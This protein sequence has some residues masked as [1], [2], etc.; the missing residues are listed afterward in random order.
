MAVRAPHV[1]HALQRRQP[2]VRG[3]DLDARL[4]GHR[5]RRDVRIVEH[6]HARRRL[7]APSGDGRDLDRPAP[8]GERSR[9]VERNLE[10]PAVAASA[11]REVDRSDRGPTRRH[12]PLDLAGLRPRDVRRQ[13]DLESPFPLLRRGPDDPVRIDRD[14]Q[15]GNGTDGAAHLALR[16]VAEA[17]R[18]ISLQEKRDSCHADPRD[19][20]QRRR[21]E[22]FAPERIGNVA[23]VIECPGHRTPQEVGERRHRSRGRGLPGPLR[24]RTGGDV[25]GLRRGRGDLPAV[26]GDEL[27]RIHRHRFTPGVP[28]RDLHLQRI[29]GRRGLAVG[30][31]VH[32]ELRRGGERG[33]SQRD[34]FVQELQ[35]A[36]GVASAG[37][38]FRPSGS[39]LREDRADRRD[40]RGKSGRHELRPRALHEGRGLAQPLLDAPA[41]GRIA[42]SGGDGGQPCIHPCEEL[43]RLRPFAPFDPGDLRLVRAG[44]LKRSHVLGPVQAPARRRDLVVGA[45]GQRVHVAGRDRERGG[46]VLVVR[47]EKGGRP[48][49]RA[50]RGQRVVDG[51]ADDPG[52]LVLAVTVVGR[53]GK[54]R[55]HDLRTES[56]R[57]AHRVFEHLVFRPEAP[58]LVQRAR[59]AEVVRP[60]EELPRAVDAPRSEELLRPHEA[61]RDAEVRAEEVL[62]PLAARQREVGDLRAHL[63]GDH[64]QQAV[65]LIVGVR[66]HDQHPPVN[67]QLLQQ[68]IERDEAAR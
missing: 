45:A 3:D 37:G 28:H 40:G 46:G 41:P 29:S 53:P 22:R 64:G 6:P 48:G 39:E 34:L 32:R 12:R 43:L 59:V 36:G 27:H 50:L 49:S 58:R 67:G 55:H 4:I 54:E 9:R 10:E 31:S 19:G 20:G 38:G 24:E 51:L 56:V 60:G 23:P 33:L 7:R 13:R 44:G 30:E 52:R 61:Q 63:P 21:L 18:D 26:R 15:G 47:T 68:T 1:S 11:G 8:G 17:P 14:L 66:S 2:D 16:L 65:V 57:D 62:S 42:D 5:S 25:A 35:G